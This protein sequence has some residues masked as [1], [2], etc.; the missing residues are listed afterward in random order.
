MVCKQGG[1]GVESESPMPLTKI[2]RSKILPCNKL[3]MHKPGGGGAAGPSPCMRH[4]PPPPP[5][6]G[7]ER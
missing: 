1:R 6:R 5:P 4:P 7:F 3:G 2:L